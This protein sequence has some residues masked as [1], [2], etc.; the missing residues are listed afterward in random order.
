MERDELSKR[1]MEK[2]KQ[3]KSKITKHNMTGISLNEEEKMRILPELKQASRMK[4]L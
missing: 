4:Y 3:G 2:E 1:I